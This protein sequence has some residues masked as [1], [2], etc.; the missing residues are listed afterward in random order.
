M[1]QARC[2]SCDS[3]AAQLRST[4]TIERAPNLRERRSLQAPTIINT[5][6]PKQSSELQGGGIACRECAV[7]LLAPQRVLDPAHRVL[8]LALGLIGSTFRLELGVAQH[9]PDPLLERAFG[10]L[11]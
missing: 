2:G 5:T 7:G 10:L 6:G 9:V 8:R 3:A 1:A 4:H 11:G